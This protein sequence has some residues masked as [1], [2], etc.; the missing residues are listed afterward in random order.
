MRRNKFFGIYYKCQNSD[1]KTL[2]FIDS[3]SND[4][5]LIQLINNETSF[6]IKDINQIEMDNNHIKCHIQQEDI[7]IHGELLFS[8][9]VPIKKDIMSFFRFLPIEC[10]HH[11]YSMNHLVNGRLVINNEEIK[12]K[13]GDGYIEGDKG[14]NFP[15]KY[16]WLNSSKKDVSLTLAIASIPLG[17]ITIKGITC[18]IKTHDKEYL[19]GTYNF[20]KIIKME[21]NHIIIKKNKYLLEIIIEEFISHKLKAPIKGEM[22]RYIH[23]CPSCK[24]RYILKYK[25][26][27]LIDKIDPFASYEYMF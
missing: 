25:N 22:V 27:I 20:A 21:K 1:G 5:H 7:N 18:L 11:I 12:F 3:F 23:E 16:L 2:A 9:F 17:L 4:G 26:E 15:N 24:I 14:K 10:K 6:L 13:H 8:N 19:F